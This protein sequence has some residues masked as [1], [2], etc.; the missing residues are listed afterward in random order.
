MNTGYA[1]AGMQFGGVFAAD[2]IRAQSTQI[3]DMTVLLNDSSE[4][5]SRLLNIVSRF[6]EFAE[7]LGK[8]GDLKPGDQRVEPTEGGAIGAL[9]GKQAW[10]YPDGSEA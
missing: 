10:I 7:R 5:Q 8:Y 3:T 6:E 4:A 1:N 2:D 9:K